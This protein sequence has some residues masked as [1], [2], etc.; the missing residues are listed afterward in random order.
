MK[1]EKGSVK[2]R[3]KEWKN[4]RAYL[5]NKKEV[6][7]REERLIRKQEEH[8]KREEQLINS[9]SSKIKNSLKI[10]FGYI[11]SII[12]SF[13][14]KKVDKI[15]IR[16]EIIQIEVDIKIV[17][18]K[19]SNDEIILPSLKKIEERLKKVEQKNVSD[20][21]KEK[22]YVLYE[23][24]S[25]LTSDI[26]RKKLINESKNIDDKQKEN[27]EQKKLDDKNLEKTTYLNDDLNI[28]QTEVIQDSKISAPIDVVPKLNNKTN[29]LK[30][31][32]SVLLAAPIVLVASG[33]NALKDNLTFN[34][35]RVENKEEE[36][37]KDIIDEVVYSNNK[38]EDIDYKKQ[39]TYIDDLKELNYE[40]RKVEL[41]LEQIKLDDDVKKEDIFLLRKKIF[42]LKDK[43]KK[44][45]E[46]NKNGEFDSILNEIEAID[47]Y[48]FSKTDEELNKLL[49][50]CGNLISNLEKQEELKEKE[51]Q[52]EKGE[53]DI[54]IS[55]M[56]LKYLEQNIEINLKEQRAEIQKINE[57]FNQVPN[58]KKRGI[59]VSGIHNF[60]SNTISIGLSILPM[61]L[62]KNPFMGALASSVI[63]NN[64]LRNMRRLIN[65]E[66]KI[67]YIKYSDI[68]K[69]IA[70]QNDC[71]YQT[72]D[73]LGDSMFQ[74]KSLRQEF[75]LEFY[76]DI[77]RY[78]ELKEIKEQF[79]AIE[80]QIESKN[81]ELK[82]ML[83]E[84]EHG[85][86]KVKKMSV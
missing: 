45:K 24:I 18:Q 1:G 66:N 16:E 10:F 48:H 60:L 14:T 19:S 62:F 51:E 64:R 32:P 8:K 22:V 69:R 74:L 59:V 81:I 61:S 54:T 35:S 56:D 28:K 5:K 2:N 13:F 41:K 9:P 46:N 6:E 72:K 33:L 71:I 49:S 7:N 43:C 42:E 17:E 3:F 75:E 67:G 47:I 53:E 21:Q 76:L 4:R 55:K 15:N 70:K 25:T 23:K 44:L 84:L 37:L 34:E 65:K 77:D 58:I 11:L 57:L 12:E 85:K 40:T 27:I 39:D 68:S 80:Y 30:I 29:N 52:E 82:E 83:K 36:S 31:Q 78:P 63:L 73:V 26:E 86:V 20:K 50:K 38:Q 79:N